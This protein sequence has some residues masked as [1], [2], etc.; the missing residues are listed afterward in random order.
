MSIRTKL[1]FGLGAALAP[2]LLA[3]P[4]FAVDE[5]FAPT[6][7]VQLPDAQILSAFDISFVDPATRTLAVAAS[8]VVGSGGAFGTVIIV[9]TDKNVVT[10]ELVPPGGFVG[11]CSVPPARDTI[12]GPNGVII[13]KKRHNADVWAADGPVFNTHCVLGSGLR[14][15]A[16]SKC[17]TWRAAPH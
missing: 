8:R 1:I 6:G 10:K 13:I 14:P 12:S 11:D 5:Q 9:N 4:T 7:I 2:W 16:P 15:P 3:V 17:S